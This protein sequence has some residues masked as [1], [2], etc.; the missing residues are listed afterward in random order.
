VNTSM[1]FIDQTKGVLL[2]LQVTMAKDICRLSFLP[3]EGEL[4]LSP[5]SVFRPSRKPEI[6]A[7]GA[8]IGWMVL[9]M[10]QD[11]GSKFYS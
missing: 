3:Q 5:N 11:T 8:L 10:V 6:V 9:D 4:L 2:R 7:G 1:G